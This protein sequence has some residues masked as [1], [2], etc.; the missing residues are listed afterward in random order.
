MAATHAHHSRY[1]TAIGAVAVRIIHRPQSAAELR[2]K[3][4][5]AERIK[6]CLDL[7]KIKLATTIDYLDSYARRGILYPYLTHPEPSGF[8]F[9][10]WLR[11]GNSPTPGTWQLAK[12]NFWAAGAFAALLWKI[13]PIAGPMDKDAPEIL[14]PPGTLIMPG[15]KMPLRKRI[16]HRRRSLWRG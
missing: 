4:P 14:F 13:C 3:I 8:N 16:L 1:R 7:A 2:A 12:A 6:L 5:L 9:F 15:K 11:R 10:N